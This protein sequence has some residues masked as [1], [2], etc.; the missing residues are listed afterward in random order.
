MI[1]LQRALRRI[2]DD[3]AGLSLTEIL[4]SAM[5]SLLI[6]VMVGTMFVQTTKITSAA[7]Q[8]SN[9]NGVASNTAIQLSSTIRVATEI[10][11]KNAPPLSAVKAGDRSSLTIYTL[12]NTSATD[13]APSQVT[14]TIDAQRLKEVRCSGVAVDGFWTFPCAG[15]ATRYFG[16]GLLLPTGTASE[17]LARQL[18]TYYD[19]NG[20]PIAIGAAALTTTQLPLVS[21]I[22]ITVRAQATGAKT[23]PVTI[24]NTVVL[25]NLG[26][27]KTE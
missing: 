24:S 23:A 2:R 26:L 11:V 3:Q 6:M 22:K 8:T 19:A 7:N 21:S 9:S 16:T 4:V 17:Q 25:S 1:R 5:L 20:A 15:A 18:F 10:A 12:S 13:P 27:E 14:Y